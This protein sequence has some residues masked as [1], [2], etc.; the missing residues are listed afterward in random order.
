MLISIPL[1]SQTEHPLSGNELD[2]KGIVANSKDTPNSAVDT[3]AA[4]NAAQVTAR[5]H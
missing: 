4:K 5:P 3:D 2:C 1:E